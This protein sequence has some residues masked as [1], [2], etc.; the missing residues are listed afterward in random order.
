MFATKKVKSKVELFL[1]DCD[2][3][4]FV[5]LSEPETITKF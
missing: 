4:F 5:Q 1:N 2:G 3:F